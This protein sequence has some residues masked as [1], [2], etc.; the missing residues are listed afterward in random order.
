MLGGRSYHR[1]DVGLDGRGEREEVEEGDHVDLWELGVSCV[2]DV[3][4]MWE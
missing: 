1:D 4:D 2:V 3:W